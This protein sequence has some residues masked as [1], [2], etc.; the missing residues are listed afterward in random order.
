MPCHFDEPDDAE[1]YAVPRAS[2]QDVQSGDLRFT[3]VSEHRS[4]RKAINLSSCR[5][6]TIHIT[7]R[8]E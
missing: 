5:L 2:W 8:F 6:R 4:F 1:V 3:R 7:T